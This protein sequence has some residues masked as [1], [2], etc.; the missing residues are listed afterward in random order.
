MVYDKLN[1]AFK[2]L[3]DDHET[4]LGMLDK[5]NKTAKQFYEEIS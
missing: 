3:E 5:C 2:E 1:K 4:V